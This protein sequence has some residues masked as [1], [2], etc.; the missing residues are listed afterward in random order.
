[1]PAVFRCPET[2]RTASQFTSYVGVT[3]PGTVFAPD[4]VCR[5]TDIT[6]GPD[7]T[8]LIV[9]TAETDIVWTEPKDLP[10]ASLSFKI[11]LDHKE[12]SSRHS[13][14][15]MVWNLWAKSPPDGANAIFCDG[16]GRFL[17]HSIPADTVRALCTIAGGEHVNEDDF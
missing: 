15:P 5:L 13:P 2:P 8:I 1:M 17:S 10:L 9:E 6:D 16:H 14:Q 3:G 12:I 4:K 11:D 7:K